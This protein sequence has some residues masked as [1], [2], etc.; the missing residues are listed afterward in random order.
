MKK[1]IGWNHPV[2]ESDQW[3]GFNDSGMEHF[4]GSPIQ[5][6]AREVNQNALD[7]SSGGIVEVRIS[8]KMVKVSEIPNI[9]ELKEN[10]RLCHHEAKQESVKAEAFFSSALVDIDKPKISIL[11]IADY[12][13][14]GMKGPAEN[15]T[16]FYAFM[17]AKGQSR[18][19]NETAT[20][21]YGIGK[22]APY[23]V[24]KLRT[25]FIS[26]VYSLGDGTHEQLTQGKSILMSHD[27]DKKR[28]QGVGF[29]GHREKCQPIKGI[30]K[31]IPSWISR[32]SSAANLNQQTGSTL[33]VL[34][35]DPLTNWET[36]LAVS[37]AENFFAAISD[38]SLRVVIND[39]YTL[40]QTTIYDFYE[41]D[42]IPALIGR[43]KNEPDQFNDCRTF[44]AA[45]KGG[46]E[47]ITEESEQRDLGLC[48]LRILVGENLPKKVCAL[49]NGMYITDSL[50]GL[51]RFSDYKDFVAVFHCQ[52]TKGNALLRAMEPPRHDDFEPERLS[53]REERR[54]GKKALDDL[55]DWIKSALKLHAKDP[56]QDVTSIDE[57]K[58]LFGDEGEGNGAKAAEEINPHGKIIIRA[59]AM[60]PKNK[61]NE[62]LDSDAQNHGHG[63]NGD[64]GDQQDGQGGGGSDGEGGGNSE[65]T[66][67]K[68]ASAGGAGA[69]IQGDQGGQHKNIM[70]I[71]NVRAV[72]TAKKGRKI[73]FTPVSTGKL[74]LRVKEAG[75]DSDYPIAITKTA[76][77]KIEDGG[78]LLE[79]KAG[80]RCSIELELT[81]EFSGALKV[82]AYEI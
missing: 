76:E 47:V 18:K 27:R 37:V 29:W 51:K 61:R 46:L 10:L 48:Q 54:K 14:T 2:D 15:G 43:L 36:Y 33:T 80:Q 81:H 73:S 82:I 79:V 49:R 17:K 44:L 30:S 60:S 22:F 8:H 9:E 62:F 5:H 39:K 64:L 20:G 72:I 71:N 13:T 45:H 78:I 50:N 26:T 24:S 12:N 58:D 1:Q 68:G 57:L 56:V 41:N 65:N 70:D 74:I 6:L 53:S 66:E 63:A 4:T 31:D 40:D 3:D 23:A 7:A 59:K 35:F 38:G 21:S 25:I 55:A 28:R 75:A 19:G 67:T 11:Q 16:P 42:E 69:G 52:S 77:G 34:G 32:A